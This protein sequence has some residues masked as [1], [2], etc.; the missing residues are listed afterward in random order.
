[1]EAPTARR[2][3]HALLRDWRTATV[4]LATFLLTLLQDVTQGVVAG[5]ALAA[6]FVVFDRIRSRSRH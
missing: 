1:L 5:C 2:I 3:S 6:L 4:L